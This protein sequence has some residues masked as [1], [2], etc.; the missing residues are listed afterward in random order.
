MSDLYRYAA[1]LR[2]I[3]VGGHRV[4]MDRLRAVIGE[5]GYTD[6]KTLIAS[7]NVVF[8]TESDDVPAL[9]AEI[10][11]HLLAELG[12]EVAT[13]LR[14]PDQLAEVVSIAQG[15]GSRDGSTD[16]W[17]GGALA[18]GQSSCYVIFFAEP[19]GSE[20][21][22]RFKN[23]CSHTDDF[24]IEGRE[25]YWRLPGKLS[26]SPLFG[27]KSER[28]MKGLQTTSRNLTTVRRLLGKL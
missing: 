28:M 20:V 14:T 27:R 11:A 15:R 8:S 9:E 7:G 4:K 25:I 12:Y 13:F 21:A 10:E 26:D 24:Q 3:N 22:T 19:L 6:V 5:L 23:A 17:R 18:G 2:G 16:T 1:L